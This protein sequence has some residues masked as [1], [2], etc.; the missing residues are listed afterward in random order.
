MGEYDFDRLTRFK[1]FDV[2]QKALND[3]NEHQRFKAVEALEAIAVASGKG[4]PAY[5]ALTEASVHSNFEDVRLHAKIALKTL[6]GTPRPSM[7]AD[8]HRGSAPQHHEPRKN[9][10]SHPQHDEQAENRFICELSPGCTALVVRGSTLNANHRIGTSP[11]AGGRWDDVE[12]AWL[13]PIDRSSLEHLKRN[14][15]KLHPTV[16]CLSTSQQE[17]WALR[18]KD[19]KFIKILGDT[20]NIDASIKKVPGSRWDRD[21]RVWKIPFSADAVKRLIKIDGLYVSP[22]ILD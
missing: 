8:N 5:K 4:G 17:T 15:V 20:A 19:K 3:D 21:E 13:L 6:D 12:K 2:L 11:S 9:Q 1:K 14:G 22:F 16:H 10:A 7:K 18:T